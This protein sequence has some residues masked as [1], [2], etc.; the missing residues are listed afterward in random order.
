MSTQESQ[1]E[2]NFSRFI[3]KLFSSYIFWGVVLIFIYM[4]PN[5]ILGKDAY[6]FMFD[7]WDSE[8]LFYKLSGKYLTK[9]SGPIPEVMNGL[10]IGSLNVFSPIQILTYMIMDAYWAFVF[11][12]FW[13]RVVG[14]LGSYLLL[15]KIFEG[16]REFIAFLCGVILAYLPV[17]SIYGTSL[18]GQGLLAYAVWNLIERKHT[19]AS[20]AYIV[21]FAISSS[22]ILTGYYILFFLLVL[23]IVLN[24][25]KGFKTALPVYITFAVIACIYFITHFKMIYHM[26]FENFVSMRVERVIYEQ[27]L[28]DFSVLF[29][30]GHFHA[31]AV[32]QYALLALIP[33]AIIFFIKLKNKTLTPAD[34]KYLNIVWALLGY[35]FLAALINRFYYSKPGI[36]ITGKLGV[37]EGFQYRRL[38]FSYPVTWNLMFGVCV[39]LLAEWGAFGKIKNF[40]AQFKKPVQSAA[41]LLL[42]FIAAFFITTTYEAVTNFEFHYPYAQNV[43][44]LFNRQTVKEN[45]ITY[46][47]YIDQE[48]FGAI[49][50]HIG[51]DT[52]DYRVVSLGMYPVI[53]S[54]NGFYTLDGYFQLYSLE[55]KH[56]F[57][58]IIAGELEKDEELR[59]YYD[60]WG[61]KCYLFSAE[62]G[63]KYEYSKSNNRPVTLNINTAK[64]K[65]M[66]G[67]YILSAV[68]IKNYNELNLNFEGLFTTPQS[69]F[70]IYLYKV[71]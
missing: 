63:M 4:L 59:L 65:E 1:T 34:K 37:L 50:E 66:G 64:L 13:V 27:K 49:K 5:L 55:Y 51:K 12:D 47:Q 61:N 10:P 19:A 2:S 25:K 70:N 58:E 53:P 11:N 17:F 57:R 41:C 35:N 18:F 54:M 32:Q 60:E 43:G 29:F 68:E 42:A 22:L 67:E 71:M 8:L 38:F 6:I 21:F 44:R 14:F 39:F 28:G 46:N 30:G 23:A 9:L 15:D 26:L 48:L 69:Y 33:V 16:K 24:A 20:Y 62:L 7:T 3:K 31:I 56:E 52:K 36:W 45:Y 40:F